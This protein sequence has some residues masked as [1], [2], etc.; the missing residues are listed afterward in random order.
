MFS[1]KDMLHVKLLS[2]YCPIILT[3]LHATEALAWLIK[4][5]K[6]TLHLSIPGSGARTL[7]I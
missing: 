1:Y 6:G 7:H 2:Q 4:A 5:K 3:Y